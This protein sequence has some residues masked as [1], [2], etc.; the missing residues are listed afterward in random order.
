MQFNQNLLDADFVR[1]LL[2]I[3]CEVFKIYVDHRDADGSRGTFHES[4][5][6]RLT[7]NPLQNSYEYHRYLE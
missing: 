5:W 4:V 6:A 3:R 7:W 2:K 1:N